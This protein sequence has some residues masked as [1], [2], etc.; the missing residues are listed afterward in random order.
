MIYIE[1]DLVISLHYHQAIEAANGA[2]FCISNQGKACSLCSDAVENDNHCMI[3]TIEVKIKLMCIPKQL[4][5][6]EN[7]EVV[8]DFSV[9]YNN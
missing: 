7:G 1:C 6:D 3:V 5:L 2:T 4:L 9:G 8:A